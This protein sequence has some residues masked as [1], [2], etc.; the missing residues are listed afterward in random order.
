M[1]GLRRRAHHADRALLAAR[2][3]VVMGRPGG[4]VARRKHCTSRV[5]F[6]H[7][8]KRDE[9]MVRR[10]APSYAA[11]VADLASPCAPQNW[12]KQRFDGILLGRKD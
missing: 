5:G 8:V 2:T 7:R 3:D 6:S 11:L 12:F 9:T 1:R 4:R 10:G